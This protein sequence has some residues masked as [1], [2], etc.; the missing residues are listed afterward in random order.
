MDPQQLEYFKE[1]LLN[2]KARLE[3]EMERSKRFNLDN[4]LSDSVQE[5]SAYDNHPADLGSELFEREKDL[6]LWNNSQEIRQR[7]EEALNHI[8][9]G[10]YGRCEDCGKEIPLERLEA[11]PQTT[12]CVECQLH[13]E[14]NHQTRER[15]IEEEVLG[16]PFGRTF[17][18][19]AD[20][21]G[22][23][24]E[25]AWQAVAKYGT[26]ESPSDLGGVDSYEDLYLDANN[27]TQGVVELTDEIAEPE[28]DS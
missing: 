17:L 9:L 3:R 19:D 11:I 12:L 21:T 7:I 18:D 13:Q 22:F 1:R 10:I 24:G 23:D 25:D 16:P 4:S 26:S 8:E 5:L 2:E 27:E 6:A 14:D 28:S 20:T 15:P